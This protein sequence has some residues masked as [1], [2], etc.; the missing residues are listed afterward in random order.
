MQR[1]TCEICKKEMHVHRLSGNRLLVVCDCEPNQ[2]F[3]QAMRLIEILVDRGFQVE[4]GES[5]MNEEKT[6]REA[7]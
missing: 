2:M 6:T 3:A 5:L 7:E 4:Y 1:E